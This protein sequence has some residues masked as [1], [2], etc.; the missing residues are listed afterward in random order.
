VA[1]TITQ[2][3]THPPSIVAISGIGGHAFGSFKE[4]GG[5]YMWLRDGLADDLTTARIMIYGYKSTIPNSKSMQTLAD[6]ALSFYTSL[7][8]LIGDEDPKPI[9]FIAHSLGGLIVKQV[10]TIN[11]LLY[12]CLT[13]SL[14][15]V[16]ISKV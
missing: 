4:R 2:I 6:L 3:Y 14:G 10:S 1:Q 13:H 8:S 7:E 16:R 5:D 11:V 15:L 12:K 9:V